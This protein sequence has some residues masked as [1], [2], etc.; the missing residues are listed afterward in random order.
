[1][2]EIDIRDFEATD[3][4]AVIA[5]ARELQTAELSFYD[6]MKPP[7]ALG[8]WYLE[9]LLES[10]AKHRGKILIATLDGE[11]VGYLAL[12]TEV[13]SEDEVIEI[14]FTY[15]LVK[16]L[17][18]TQRCR[19]QGMGRRLLDRAEAEA[20]KSG[21]RWLRVGVLTE[22]ESAFGLYRKS[23]FGPL[24]TTLEKPL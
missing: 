5:L 11:A 6:R 21:A 23:G 16:D 22:N 9:H 15:A 24:G 7:E 19:G 20:R 13:S 10:C 1:M 14:E 3:G 4:P 18:V 12:L 8:D 17:A 2:A